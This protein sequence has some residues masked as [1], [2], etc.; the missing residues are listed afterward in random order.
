MRVISAER[1]VYHVAAHFDG[2]CHIVHVDGIVLPFGDQNF[3][4]YVMSAKTYKNLYAFCR[5]IFLVTCFLSCC[6][7]LCKAAVRLRGQSFRQGSKA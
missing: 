7:R 1:L 6:C 2:D 3:C 4:F 5:T